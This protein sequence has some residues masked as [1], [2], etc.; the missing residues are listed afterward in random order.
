MASKQAVRALA[1]RSSVSSSTIGRQASRVSFNTTRAFSVAP[2]SQVFFKDLGNGRHAVSGVSGGGPS[3][4]AVHKRWHSRAPEDLKQNKVYQFDDV[5]PFLFL[6]FHLAHTTS[7]PCLPAP[8]LTHCKGSAYSRNPLRLTPPHRRARTPR[9]REEQH[10]HRHK[11]T[12]YLATRCTVARRRRLPGSLW[13]P[14]TAQGEGGS[15]LL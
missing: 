12:G 9:I 1:S 14:E 13:L 4:T 6:P 5:R 2:P 10:P 11:H 3:Y 15:V 7:S 8:Y